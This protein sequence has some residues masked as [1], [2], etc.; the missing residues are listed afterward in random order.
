MGYWGHLAF[1]ALGLCST[2][3][4]SL[5]KCSCDPGAKGDRGPPGP[6][7]PPGFWGYPPMGP[8]PPNLPLIPGPR[9]LPGPPGPPG[10]CFPCPAVPP[11]I[12]P[13]IPPVVPPVVPPGVP[14]P[15]LIST[16]AVPGGGFGAA[17]AL[18]TAVGNIIV[19]PGGVL[20]GRAQFFHISPDGQV[21]QIERPQ[22]LPSELFDSPAAQS[23]QPQPTSASLSGIT[24]PAVQGAP[25][26]A[27]PGELFP[28]QTT[29]LPENLEETVYA[30]GNRKDFLRGSTDASDWRRI[31]LLGERSHDGLL[32]PKGHSVQQHNPNQLE[33][34]M[35]NFQKAL[36]ELKE[37]YA[38]LIQPRSS[39]Q[40][41]VII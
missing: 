32:T 41:A 14:V 19:I 35:E 16:Q 20:N 6:P 22:N 12:P 11:V 39:N 10:Y 23:P 1:L 13:V 29:S 38:T 15:P 24:P 25:T 36:V 37:K 26:Q 21:M 5:V 30:V 40:Y 9:G 17:S 33:N 27:T 18:T 3:Q 4:S 28:P 8:Y 2:V 7:G 34:S 31:L